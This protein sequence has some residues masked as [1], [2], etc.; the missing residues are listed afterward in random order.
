MSEGKTSILTK[1]NVEVAG[2]LTCES[3]QNIGQGQDIDVCFVSS[4]CLRS[5]AK[6]TSSEWWKLTPTREDALQVYGLEHLAG[7][8]TVDALHAVLRQLKLL[9][10]QE[11]RLAGLLGGV[12]REDEDDEDTAGHGDDSAEDTACQPQPEW[13]GRHRLAVHGKEGL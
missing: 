11:P 2:R 9:L 10:S 6:R 7:L 1:E 12:V 8:H 5:A 13:C 3:V 4:G